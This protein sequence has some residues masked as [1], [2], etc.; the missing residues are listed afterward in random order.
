LS[1]VEKMCVCLGFLSLGYL[2]EDLCGFGMFGGW[3]SWFRVCLFSTGFKF[4]FPAWAWLLV[5]CFR[6]G[7]RVGR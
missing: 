7:Q 2:M 5:P 6:R 1:P 3:G 4:V